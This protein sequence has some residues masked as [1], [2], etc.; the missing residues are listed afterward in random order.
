MKGLRQLPPAM[1]PVVAA[2][3]GAVEETFYRGVLLGI[4]TMRFS[5]PPIA[6]VAISGTLFCVE[7]LL[8][9]RTAFQ[10]MII[11]SGCVAISMV[12]GLLV[13]ARGSFVPA[14]LCH[15]SFVLFFMNQGSQRRRA[16]TRAVTT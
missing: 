12:G 2:L 9:V 16:G 13:V 1:V 6:A 4:L 8:Q 5:V 15:A 14:A 10:A 7:Q 11:A 3:A